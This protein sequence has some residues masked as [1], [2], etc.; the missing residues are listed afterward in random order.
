MPIEVAESL[1]ARAEVGEVIESPAHPH[2]NRIKVVPALRIGEAA[3][4][5]HHARA[6]ATLSVGRV[7]HSGIVAAEGD[8]FVPE[9]GSIFLRAVY[10]SHQLFKLHMVL[11]HHRRRPMTPVQNAVV[12]ISP[13]FVPAR[14][15]L[16]RDH[17]ERGVLEEDP[18]PPLAGP[19]LQ[20]PPAS[21]APG[22][23]VE[24]SNRVALPERA[25]QH[26]VQAEQVR[27]A[28]TEHAGREGELAD[29]GFQVLRADLVAGEE[30]FSQ[31]EELLPSRIADRDGASLAVD[32]VA[33]VAEL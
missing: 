27:A 24:T 21:V 29:G 11:L 13:G 17:R 8:D 9:L 10:E 25:L 6:A 14:V 5:L 16:E 23:V 30:P 19:E 7:A 31:A 26:L 15:G 3:Q 20:A 1:K 22:A 4:Q 12:H 33:N 2:S 18:R 28:A 32:L